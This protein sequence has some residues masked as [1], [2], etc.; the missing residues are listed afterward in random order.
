MYSDRKEERKEVREGG[1][2]GERQAVSYT[3]M[4]SKKCSVMAELEMTILQL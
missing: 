3:R 1:K 2:K 4:P